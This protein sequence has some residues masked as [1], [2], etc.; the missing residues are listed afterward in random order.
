MTIE[1]HL[2]VACVNYFRLKYP[3][4]M[5]YHVANERKT[6]KARGAKLKRMGVLAGVSDLH[7]PKPSELYNGL[8]V[9]LKYDKWKKGKKVKASWPTPEQLDFLNKMNQYRRAVAVCWNIDD[10]MELVDKYMN[11]QPVECE[12]LIKNGHLKL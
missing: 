4:D 5:I 6:S 7:I 12:Y 1:E 10:F 9:E 8:I 2:T 3:K 11:N